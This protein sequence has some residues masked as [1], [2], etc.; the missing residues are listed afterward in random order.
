MAHE[1]AS[2]GEA[3]RTGSV[4]RSAESSS[5]GDGT[6]LDLSRGSTP[7][8]EDGTL[9]V[10][11]AYGE[12]IARDGGKR[13]PTPFRVVPTTEDPTID[14][15]AGER[16]S[17]ATVIARLAMQVVRPLSTE[18]WRAISQATPVKASAADVAESV[19]A[20]IR[21]KLAKYPMATDRSSLVLLIDA[22]TALNA[23]LQVVTDDLRVSHAAEAATAG[24]KEIWLVGPTEALIHRL[25]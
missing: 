19:M 10:A 12:R 17:N 20:A 14:V 15:V 18:T 6:S 22:T 25:A 2:S 21:T 4:A 7:K 24:F 1:I 3:I 8:N 23:A 9:A 5:G 13:W 16:D 11:H